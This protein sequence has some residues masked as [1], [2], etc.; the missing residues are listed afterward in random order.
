MAE[1]EMGA[2][3]GFSG[4]ATQ[5]ID[6]G[7]SDLLMPDRA[8]KTRSVVRDVEDASFE[9][10]GKPRQVQTEPAMVRRDSQAFRSRMADFPPYG[11]V[12]RDFVAPERRGPDPSSAIGVGP[13]D[14]LGVFAGGIASNAASKG[15]QPKAWAALAL[16][17]GIVAVAAF[18][19]TGGHA[20]LLEPATPVQASTVTAPAAPATLVS[21][22]TLLKPDP[23]VTSSIV[24]L[25][26]S[27][28]VTSIIHPKPRP[29]RIERA[30]AILMIRPNSD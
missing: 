17:V 8:R 6:P 16:T 3:M 9:T 29:A 23:V 4:R 7:S 1:A 21:K 18:W 28:A 26:A 27:P 5:A 30:G 22:A 20:L 13:N 25:P 12:P 15:G 11:P 2:A 14:R 19:M 10:L 24:I